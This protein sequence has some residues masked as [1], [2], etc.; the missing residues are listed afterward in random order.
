MGR[1]EHP[2][3]ELRCGLSDG[4]PEQVPQQ[5]LELPGA[6]ELSLGVRVPQCG[7]GFVLPV[8]E[9]VGVL[10]DRVFDAAHALGRLVVAV[11]S[12]LVP[13]AFPDLVERVGHPG[14]D[15]EAVEH[16]LG[17]RAPF[18]HARVDPLRPVAGHHLDGRFLLV[19]ELL[20]EHV[21]HVPAVP[22]V[23]PYHPM[24]LV[25]DDDGQ[26]RVALPVAGLVHADG[27][28]PVERRGRRGLQPAGDPA[29][30]LAGGPPRHVQETAHGLLVGDGH[31]PRALR[32]EVPGEPASRLCPR[33]GGDHDA[34]S[35]A[36]TLGIMETSSTR[37]QPK[38]R[39]RQRRTPPPRS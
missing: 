26:I 6:V 29:G 30:D 16:A 31:Q 25:V 39:W 23:R 12:R 14:D 18:M 35:G 21:E 22:V 24:P 27:V 15:V 38:F 9:M 20:E 17:V 32:L 1:P 10:Q 19:G 36:V 7:E 5:F 13:E 8:G 37:Q 4:V 11:A 28:Q 33:H 2:M 3:P 34:A